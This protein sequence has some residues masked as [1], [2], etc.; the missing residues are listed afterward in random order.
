[1]VGGVE[2][3]RREMTVGK[4]RRRGRDDP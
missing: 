3:R 2:T 4:S 1:V